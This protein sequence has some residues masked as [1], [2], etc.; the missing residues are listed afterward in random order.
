MIILVGDF[1]IVFMGDGE[2]TEITIMNLMNPFVE[3]ITET[4]TFDVVFIEI[5][6]GWVHIYDEEYEE[7]DVFI[8]TMHS[9]TENML[10]GVVETPLGVNY[11]IGH[12]L[13]F[14]P[15]DF[16]DGLATKSICEFRK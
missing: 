1:F 6:V 11:I 2:Q 4:F 13:N 5:G 12:N 16:A 14:I 15:Y 8:E 10:I 9:I 3:D 7:I